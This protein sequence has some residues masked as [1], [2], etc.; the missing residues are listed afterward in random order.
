MIKCRINFRKGKI[1]KFCANR[2]SG[3][4]C[5][6]AKKRVKLQDS[7]DYFH[8]SDCPTSAL[9]N[10]AASHTP[11]LVNLSPDRNRG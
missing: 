5:I 8:K 4:W 7:C 6:L 9:G 10:P 1:C 11:S 2:L 3:R